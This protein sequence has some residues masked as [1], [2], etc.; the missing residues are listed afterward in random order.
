MATLEEEQTKLNE[1]TNTLKKLGEIQ[2]GNLTRQDLGQELN[3]SG[4]E[5]YFVRT[6]GL[7]AELAKADL[8]IFPYER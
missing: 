8:A 3:F 1:L 7:F 2:P 4:G 5:E 6:L